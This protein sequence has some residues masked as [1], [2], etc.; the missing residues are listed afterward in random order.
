MFTRIRVALQSRDSMRRAVDFLIAALL[1]RWPPSLR[2]ALFRGKRH[3]CPLC[4]A[5]L[6]RFLVLHRPFFR[7]CPVCRSLQRHWM[8]WLYIR[9]HIL[10][11]HAI[12]QMLHI[13]PEEA[14]R[15]AFYHLPGVTY[16][17]MD[18]DAAS[19]LVCA[20]ARRLPFAS[21]MF[22]FIYCSHVLEHIPDDRTAMRELQRVLRPGGMAM[23]LTPLWD[24][25]TFE[26][27]M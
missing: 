18:L 4:G 21:R 11:M 5:H 23:I 27:Q 3:E 25:P 26:D 1:F 10:P 16:V 19:V 12:R 2:A 7:W 17:S 8:S 6:S 13:A 24:K 22:D 20:D 15:Q 14:L 9:Q